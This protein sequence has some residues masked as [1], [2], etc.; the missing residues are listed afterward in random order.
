MTCPFCS[1]RVIRL[2]VRESINLEPYC[3]LDMS[4]AILLAVDLILR[5]LLLPRTRS[6]SLTMPVIVPH[7]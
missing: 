7:I 3:K 5:C 6:N 1:G 2:L 4:V